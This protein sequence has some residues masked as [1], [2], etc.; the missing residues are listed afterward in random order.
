MQM[1]IKIEDYELWNTVIKDPYVL[2]TM[3]DGKIVVKN[4]D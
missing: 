1:F 3:I 4:E 2:K